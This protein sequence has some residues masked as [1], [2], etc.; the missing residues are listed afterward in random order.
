MASP[1][2]S[3]PLVIALAMN[4]GFR[5]DLETKL[6]GAQPHVT[7]LMAN[8]QGI[9]NY[10]EIVE[11][12]EAVDGVIAAAPAIYQR[13]LLTNG[14]RE[15]GAFMKGI[16]PELEKR[17]STALDNL[18]EGQIDEFDDFSILL[19]DELAAY[20]GSLCGRSSPGRSVS[21]R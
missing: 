12:A 6:L 11:R 18:V 8:G 16:I 4:T 7:L 20:M 21:R 14:F 17:R 10:M 15:D 19:G 13:V 5:Q 2:V 1:P 3:R 9:E